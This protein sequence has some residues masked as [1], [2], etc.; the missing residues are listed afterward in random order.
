MCYYIGRM[1]RANINNNKRK[2]KLKS[3]LLLL[4][5]VFLGITTYFLVSDRTS[6]VSAINF[7]FSSKTAAVEYETFDI[8]LED[9]DEE[10]SSKIKENL[11]KIQFQEKPRFRF[12]EKKKRADIILKYGT[13]EGALFTEFLL[14][15]GHMYWIKD[16]ILSTDLLE[17]EYKVLLNEQSYGKYSEFL[18]SKYPDINVEKSK[19]L[20]TDLGNEECNCI[21][22]IEDNEL[23][24]EFKL[25][26][27]DDKYYLDTFEG[28]IEISLEAYSQRKDINMGF[29]SNIIKRN[30]GVKDIEFNEE[31]VAKVNMTGVT[32]MARRVALAMDMRKNYT[33][34]AEKIAAFLSDAD[35]THTSNEVSFVDGCN[36]Y[37]GMRFCSPPQSIETLKAIGVDVI[38]LTGNHNNDFGSKYNTQTIEKYKEEGIAY[39]GGGLNIEDASKPY[40]TEVDGTTISFLGYNYYDAIVAGGS[41]ALARENSAGANAYSEEKME[42]DIEGLRESTDIIIVDFQFQECYSYP[43]GDVIYPVCYKPINNQT[44]VFRK[45]IDYGADIVVGTQAHQPQTYEL[46]KDG[47]IFYG[48]GNLF[49]DQSMWIGTRQGMVLT[50]YFKEGALIQTKIT[51]TIYDRSLQVEVANEKDSQLL[52]ELLS[53]ARE[54]L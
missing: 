25:L 5:F 47:V 9:I 48:L 15:V 3:Y 50:H 26:K 7:L 34:P 11:E 12:T 52:L 53:T 18:K 14:P 46:Y 35:L 41:N 27:M 54:S 36:A 19:S 43:S 38:E 13:G 6:T 24:K 16:R 28:A 31:N 10:Y 33:Y 45:A 23:T 2:S 22:L 21:G 51:P 37:T 29:V 40:I 42:K 8:Y 32:A 4:L 44:S 1:G 17:G 39:F 49:F 30:M 20:L